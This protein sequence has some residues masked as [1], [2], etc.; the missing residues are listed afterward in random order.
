LDEKG[1]GLMNWRIDFPE[2][3]DDC[4]EGTGSEGGWKGIDEFED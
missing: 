4:S 1:D 3:L 2:F